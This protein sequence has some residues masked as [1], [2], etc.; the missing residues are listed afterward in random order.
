MLAVGRLS[1][2]AAFLPPSRDILGV[3]SKG[4]HLLFRGPWN[5]IPACVL[6]HARVIGL[7]SQARDLSIISQSSRICVASC[8]ST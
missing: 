6:N 5:A 7:P 8:T 4:L 1:Y 3:E 2:A